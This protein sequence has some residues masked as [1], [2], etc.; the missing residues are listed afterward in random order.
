MSFANNTPIQFLP[1]IG[2]RTA[3]VL[4]DLG[5]HTAGQLTTV[6][7]NMLIELFGPSIRSVVKFVTVR[8]VTHATPPIQKQPLYSSMYAAPSTHSGSWLTR[9]RKAMKLAAF[10]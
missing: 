1:G 7:E 5:V 10:L 8:P 9:V 3:K 6:P 2:P 4:H